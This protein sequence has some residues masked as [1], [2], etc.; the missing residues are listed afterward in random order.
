VKLVDSNIWLYALVAP[1]DPSKRKKAIEICAD[2]DICVSS[3]VVNEVLSNLLRKE[4]ASEEEVRKVL[5][6]FYSQYLVLEILQADI[7]TAS[8]LREEYRFSYWDSLIVATALRA[9]A[10][11]LYS[12][13]MQDGLIT[14][15][16]LTI[17]NPFR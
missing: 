10:D 11:T 13:D 17:R 16:R 14:R 8:E 9:N 12:E 7:Q 6:E 3:Q 1:S 2:I 5:D 4:S 15:G